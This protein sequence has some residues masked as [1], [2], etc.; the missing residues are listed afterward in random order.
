MWLW[1]WQLSLTRRSCT[2]AEEEEESDGEDGDDESEPLVEPLRQ[3]GVQAHV[4]A[5]VRRRRPR[6]QLEPYE[7]VLTNRDLWAPATVAHQYRRR[8]VQELQMLQPWGAMLP[9]DLR[10]RSGGPP[11]EAIRQCAPLLL[12][13]CDRNVARGAAVFEVCKRVACAEGSCGCPRR[14]RA[15]W[16]G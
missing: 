9:S 16:S 7:V 10:D 4:R 15:R 6:E 5:T 13:L 8:D 12:P 14:W 11:S 3:S 2:D 1:L